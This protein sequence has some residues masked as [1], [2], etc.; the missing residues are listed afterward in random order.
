MKCYYYRYNDYI[1]SDSEGE[2][3]LPEHVTV[4]TLAESALIL[5]ML[6]IIG[7]KGIE[8]HRPEVQPL[9]VVL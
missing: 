4:A 5:L 3:E 9:N 2:T 1:E 8:K 6:P 7:L